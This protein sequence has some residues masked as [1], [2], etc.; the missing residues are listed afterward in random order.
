MAGLSYSVEGDLWLPVSLIVAI[1]S[2]WS[3]LTPYPFYS[4]RLSPLERELFD[5]EEKLLELIENHPWRQNSWMLAGHSDKISR[6]LVLT[7]L[8]SPLPLEKNP[9]A[10]VA[11]I[12]AEIAERSGIIKRAIASL[13]DCALEPQFQVAGNSAVVNPGNFVGYA[14]I[15]TDCR[16]GARRLGLGWESCSRRGIIEFTR[17]F[18]S[19]D[20]T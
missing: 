15:Y 4:D 16:K 14:R 6:Q 7:L 12:A 10:Q 3:L 19:A 5:R 20:R 18:G 8:Q 9:A 1:Q 11:L 17:S 13:K 2:P